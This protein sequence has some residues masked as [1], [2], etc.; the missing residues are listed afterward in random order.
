MLAS[1]MAQ[2]LSRCCVAGLENLRFVRLT[3]GF[4]ARLFE[5]EVSLDAVH[6]LIADHALVSQFDQS[7]AL[8][9]QQLPQEALVGG[10]AFLHPPSSSP[11][12]RARKRLRR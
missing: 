5:V 3:S 7:P 6:D 11:P 9:S 2:A 10:G 12:K 4:Q 8:C 1:L